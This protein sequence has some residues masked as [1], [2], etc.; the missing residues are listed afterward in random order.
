MG[1]KIK[2]INAMNIEDLKN[3]IDELKMELIKMNA[4]VATGTTPKSPGQLKENKKTIAKILTV[5][6]KK[7]SKKE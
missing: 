2:D 5:I 7:E 1:L 3:K 4:Q 6:G